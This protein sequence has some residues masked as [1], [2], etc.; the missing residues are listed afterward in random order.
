[1]TVIATTVIVATRFATAQAFAMYLLSDLELLALATCAAI[2]VVNPGRIQEVLRA[3]TR[4]ERAFRPQVIVANR[5]T[6]YIAIIFRYYSMWFFASLSFVLWQSDH[7]YFSGV[8]GSSS[9]L[10]IFWQFVQNSFLTITN[11]NNNLN[12]KR[13]LSQ[14]SSDVE[15][16]VGIFLLVFLFAVL[17]SS[18]AERAPNRTEAIQTIRDDSEGE[19]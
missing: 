6:I 19:T 9:R 1:V 8:S 18:W 15:L 13:F 17:V 4:R 12:P 16:M 2:A 14:L 11:S 7:T 3:V 10:F 5:T